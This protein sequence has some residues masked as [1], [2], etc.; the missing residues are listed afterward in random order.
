MESQQNGILAITALQGCFGITRMFIGDFFG[1]SYA[2]MLATLGYNSRFPGPAVNWLKTYI[3]ITSINGTVSTVD[4]IQSLLI[5]NISVICKTNLFNF[6][7][8][9]KRNY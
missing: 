6:F 2:L 7:C 8:H 4:L 3:L 5:G 9:F 1:G